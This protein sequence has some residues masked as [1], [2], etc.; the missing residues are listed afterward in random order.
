LILGF[1][2]AARQLR[3][4][5]I[6]RRRKTRAGKNFYPVGSRSDSFGAFPP[7]SLPF[8]PPKRSVWRAKRG[9][10]FRSK[11]VLISSSKR[12][13]IKLSGILPID[14]AARSA[15][16]LVGQKSESLILVYLYNH[17]RTYFSK[18]L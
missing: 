8:C 11:K 12:T 18:N 6:R 4:H 2:V 5:E 9:G 10:Q 14:S 3:W 17:T 1:S 13:T 16:N 7:T 15:A